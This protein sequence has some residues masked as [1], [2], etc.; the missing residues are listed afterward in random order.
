M[1][2][3]P[4]LIFV[5]TFCMFAMASTA[6]GTEKPVPEPAIHTGTGWNLTPSGMLWVGYDLDHNGQADYYTLRIVLKAYFSND[7]IQAIRENSPMSPVFY[8]DYDKDRYFYITASNPIFYAF[9]FDEDGHWDLMF[10]DALEDGVNGNEKFYD[11]PS[12]KYDKEGIIKIP[13]S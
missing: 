13:V 11:S 10:K 7:S 9:D 1:K 5:W 4:F 8:V 3:L 2:R 6:M 12:G